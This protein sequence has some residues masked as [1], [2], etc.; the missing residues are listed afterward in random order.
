MRPYL[1]PVVVFLHYSLSAQERRPIHFGDVSA[2]EMKMSAYERDS[3]ASAVI[4]HDK[5]YFNGDRFEF[6]RHVRIKIISAAGTSFGNF[7]LRVPSKGFIDGYT[8]NMNNGLL[9]RTK[10]EKSN[11]YNEE[12]VDGFDVYKVFF[13][14][15]KP[16]SVIDLRYTH[17]GLPFEWRFQDVIPVR[18]SE[19]ILER[20]TNVL[21]K[22]VFYG[23]EKVSERKPGEFVAEN[24]PAIRL[25]P[26]MNHYSNYVT[27]F[28]FDI[29]SISFPR[30]N[31]DRDFSTSWEM[32]GK[33]LM[34]N[35]FFGGIIRGSVFLNEKAREIKQSEGSATDKVNMAVNYIRDNIKWN[36]NV[37]VIATKSF[38]EDFK[39]NHSGNSGT[40]NLLL[41]SLLRKSGIDVSPVVLST[42]DNGM[43]NPLSAS[44]NKVNYVLAYVKV[45]DGFLLV[46]AT[47][48]HTIPGVLPAHCL[49][50]L[51]WVIERD[52]TGQL[53]E[54]IPHRASDL[55]RFIRITTNER[56]ELIAEVT[57][58]YLGYAYLDWVT[59]FDKSASEKSYAEFLLS[60]NRNALIDTYVLLTRDKDTMKASERIT[61]KLS[62][63]DHV[64]PIGTR[65]IAINPHAFDDLVN[66][67]NANDRLYPIDFIYP[68]TKTTTIS[69]TLPPGYDLKSLP[70]AQKIDYPDGKAK[71]MFL[72][73]VSNNLVN[74]Q[75]NLTFRDILFME[76]EHEVLREFYSEVI[77]KLNESVQVIKKL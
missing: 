37:G 6:T 40:I 65:E 73:G 15:V 72:S 34:E 7:T 46:D 2:A 36:Y 71:F 32:V 68:L 59:E 22:K 29:E 13:P 19:L 23:L 25:E 30:W 76:E 11:I 33:R 53:V 50:N 56:N 51:G 47:N 31:F 16:G 1:L 9:R 58:T 41:I 20:T 24:V 74:I 61:F 45:Q 52:E 69:M 49:N 66:P 57:S 60:K 54:L 3:T 14:E 48:P 26:M 44:L 17:L 28:Q 64:Q 35:E 38:R 75:C 43:I 77:K 27:R 67:F 5:G 10:L 4:L 63:T 8:F 62:G 18:Y 12:I 55:K 21:Y 70:Q 39:I 42:R